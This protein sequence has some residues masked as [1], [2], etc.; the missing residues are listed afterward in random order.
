MIVLKCAALALLVPVYL[1]A[2]F[3]AFNAVRELATDY[4]AGIGWD[5]GK[6]LGFS[7]L[8]LV[9]VMTGAAAGSILSGLL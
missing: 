2:M 3:G 9:M 8:I 7:A 1:L 5:S 6:T 4:H